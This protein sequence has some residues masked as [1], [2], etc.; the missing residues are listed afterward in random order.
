MVRVAAQ[1]ATAGDVADLRAIHEEQKSN[2]GDAM[3]FIEADMRFHLRLAEMT[4][5]PI[6]VSVSQAMLGWLFE[7]HVSLLHWS[8]KEDVTLAEHEEMINLIE[9]HDVEAAVATMARHIERS[10]GEFE[11]KT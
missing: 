5:N 6:I 10:S 1:K 11:A 3:A 4:D 2:T 8:G 7:Y 9:K